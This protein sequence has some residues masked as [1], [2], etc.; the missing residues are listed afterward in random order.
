VGVRRVSVPFPDNFI[1]ASQDVIIDYETGGPD[2]KG[3]NGPDI[4][5]PV[6]EKR[7]S[8]DVVGPHDTLEYGIEGLPT[9]EEKSKGFISGSFVRD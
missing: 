5:V 2:V 3:V 6:D 7:E 1:E 8:V 4:K 9:E